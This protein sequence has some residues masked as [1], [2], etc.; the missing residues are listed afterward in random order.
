MFLKEPAPVG[1][2]KGEVV[3]LNLMLD[4]YYT[5]RG[6]DLQTGLVPRSRL[7]DLGLKYIADELE[8]MKKLPDG[9]TGSK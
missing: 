6:Y 2:C 9:N 7:E 8:K 5:S 1:L 4:E 3:D